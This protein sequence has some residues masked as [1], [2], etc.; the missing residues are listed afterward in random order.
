MRGNYLKKH[1]LEDH[2]LAQRARLEFYRALETGRMIAFVGAMGTEAFGYGDWGVLIE[3]FSSTA[4]KVLDD[5]KPPSGGKY[6]TNEQMSQAIGRARDQIA[7]FETAIMQKSIDAVTGMSLIEEALTLPELRGILAESQLDESDRT[8]TWPLDQAETIHEEMRVRLAQ[9]YRRPETN[10]QASPGATATDFPAYDVPD[11]LWRQ[12]GIRRFA[13]PSYDF[14]IERCTMLGDRPTFSANPPGFT[15]PFA[16][17][18]VMR[19]M[20]DKV[21][22]DSFHWDLGSGRIRRVYADGWAVESD[23]VNR[24]RIDRMIEFA[25]GT[26]DVDAHIMHLHGRA[27]NWRSMIVSRRDYDNLYRRNDLNRAPFEFAKKMMIG[28]N[29]L[30][31]VGLGMGEPELNREMEEF[32]SNAPYQRVAPTFLLWNAGDRLK[33]REK[34]RAFRLEKLARFGVL[35]IFDTDLDQSAA[36]VVAAPP[37]RDPV[38]GPSLFSLA[39]VVRS[40][41]PSTSAS[42]LK[43]PTRREMHVGER[44]RDMAGRIAPTGGPTILWGLK[45]D[46][47]ATDLPKVRQFARRVRSS[48]M[49]ALIGAQGCG[50]GSVVSGIVKIIKNDPKKFG[51]SRPENCLIINGG[52]AFDTDTLLDALA[53]FFGRTLDARAHAGWRSASNKPVSSRSKYFKSLNIGSSPIFD[54]NCLVIINGLERFCGVNGEPLSAELDELLRMVVRAGVK[55]PQARFILLGSA[56]I[57]K[58]CESINCNMVEFDEI[59]RPPTM[60]GRSKGA[61]FSVP[62][63]Y[64][65]EVAKFAKTRG[66]RESEGL[67]RAV[68]RYDAN[69][70][71]HVS[72]DLIDLRR[73]VFS[74]IFDDDNLRRVIGAA[75]GVPASREEV[76]TTRLVLRALAFIGAPVEQSVLCRMP[77]LQD[78]VGAIATV[79]ERLC[80]AALVLELNGYRA[81][82]H[83]NDETP[84]YALHRSLLTEL[85]YRFGI[86]LNEAKLSTAF[87]MALYVAQPIDGDIPDSDIHDELGEAIDRLIGSYHHASASEITDLAGKVRAHG[88]APMAVA[89]EVA[90]ACGHSGVHPDMTDHSAAMLALCSREYVQALRAA[91]AMIRGYYSTTG[92]LTL[93]SGDRLASVERDGILLEHAE[94]LDTLIDAYGKITLAREKMRT[95]IAD[96]AVFATIFGLAEPFYADELVWMHN[97]RGVVRLAMGD[98]YEARRSFDQAMRVNRDWVEADDPGHNWRR[99]RINQLMVEMEMGEIGRVERFCDEI[100]RVTP[101][102]AEAQSEEDRRALAIVDAHRAWVLQLRGDV[103]AARTLFGKAL[104]VFTDLREVRAYAYFASLN[105]VLQDEEPSAD[106][107]TARITA[108]LHMAQSARQMDIVHRVQVS[109]ATA[110][111]LDNPERPPSN[112]TRQRANRMLEEALTYAIQADVHRVRLEASM[113]IARARLQTADYEGA[114]RYAMDAMMIAARYGMELRKIALRA[115]IAQVMVARGHPVTA[116]RLARTCIKMATRKRFQTAIDR[117]ER[118]ILDIPRVSTSISRSDGSG[119]RDF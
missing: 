80:A 20:R 14:E 13:T 34:Q 29:P 16:D 68:A 10:M 25:V 60:S 106:K 19:A 69:G 54:R 30:L 104:R 52:F 87:N 53:L 103:P 48:S 105:A 1:Y 119:R 81:V 113:T 40:L 46:L 41:A 116:E 89:L 109:L 114:L 107:R 95:R 91:L 112:E 44:W 98:L 62:G 108:A 83:A 101:A 42:M 63:V 8:R 45:Q 79:L 84:R 77:G 28:G 100:V 67:R 94:R 55:H 51:L 33:S 117:A 57:R 12:L 72:G 115:V 50:K 111:L 96:D 92:L 66:V 78:R 71:T 36:T 24:E 11:A 75:A 99:I 86:P 110:W 22:Q 61:A 39:H 58:Y 4:K 23:M 3:R 56:R 90:V 76:M 93:D 65:G 6:P 35:T 85:R 21:E 74:L 70:A 26:D 5:I 37:P 118:V 64:L 18:R 73:E 47:K 7:T 32:I 88:R 27:C 49:T 102:T 38:R 59:F 82:T 17:L 15:D 2:K 97:E 43:Q 31:F 9:R